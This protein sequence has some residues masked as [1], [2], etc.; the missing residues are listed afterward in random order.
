MIISYFKANKKIPIT[1]I[2]LLAIQCIMVYKLIMPLMVEKVCFLLQ[3]THSQVKL[4]GIMNKQKKIGFTGD[5]FV[6]SYM[7]GQHNT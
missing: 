2:L 4:S 1:Q 3:I 6:I 5:N 7:I